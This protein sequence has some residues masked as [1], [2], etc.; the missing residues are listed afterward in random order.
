[1]KDLFANDPIFKVRHRD[2]RGRFATEDRAARDNAVS[3]NRWL[4]LEVEKYKRIANL[5]TD[6]FITMQRAI[7]QQKQ[8]IASLR[9]E[10]AQ[11]QKSK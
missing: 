11:L 1:M 6:S 2:R 7:A 10:L 4:R 8:T 3:E 9:N 5:S